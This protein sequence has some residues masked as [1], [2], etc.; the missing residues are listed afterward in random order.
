MWK[1]CLILGLSVW[2]VAG[3]PAPI[4]V[5]EEEEEDVCLTSTDSTPPEAE[6]VFPFT[7]N[8][9]TYYGCPTDPVDETKRWCSIKTDENGVHVEGEGTWGYCTVGCKPEIFP[10]ILPFLKIA[11]F[12]FIE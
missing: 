2:F 7:F 9:F 12:P 3:N 1:F 11:Y 10:G 5:E 4:E 8:N 6:C